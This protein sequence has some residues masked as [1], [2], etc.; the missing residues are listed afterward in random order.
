MADWL[1]QTDEEL[2][3][4][5]ARRAKIHALQELGL[6]KKEARAIL[7][8][9]GGNVQLAVEAVLGDAPPPEAPTQEVQLAV[10]AD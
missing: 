7:K 8:L 10:E 9:V 2:A 1:R 3:R 5:E 4:R 6:D